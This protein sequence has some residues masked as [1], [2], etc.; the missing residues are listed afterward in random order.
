MKRKEFSITDEETED[1]DEDYDI[2][3]DENLLES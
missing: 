3:K 2:E 1:P